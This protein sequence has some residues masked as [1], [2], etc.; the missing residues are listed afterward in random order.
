MV[1]FLKKNADKDK[2]SR[3]ISYIGEKNAKVMTCPGETGDLLCLS[4]DTSAIDIDRIRAMD[5]VEDAKRITPASRLSS[6]R[7]IGQDTAVRVGDAVFGGGGFGIIA[8]PCSVESQDQISSIAKEIKS[9][10]AAVLRGGAF[11]PRTSPYSFQGLGED[12]IKMLVNAKKESGL[13]I[14]TEATDASCLRFFDEVDMIQVGARTM[15]N[16]ELLKELSHIKKPVLLKRNA[17]CTIDEL[18]MSA[19]YLISGGNGNVILCERGIRTFETETR[20]TLDISAVPVIKRL[21]HLPV[22]VDPSHGTGARELVLPMALAAA[23]AGADGLMI[24]VH[25]DPE[26]ALCDGPQALTPSEF[27]DLSA[28]VSGI[29]PFSYKNMG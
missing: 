25:N 5:I 8:G 27:S 15:Q 9:A 28:R 20:Y 16:F 21:S 23:A 3:L 29:L 26:R 2:I 17:G 22:I 18:L 14:V 19:E 11:K 13:P 24:E 12:G 7:P 4:G 1:I 6:R 10:G